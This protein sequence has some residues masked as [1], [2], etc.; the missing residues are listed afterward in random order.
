MRNSNSLPIIIEG[1]K[2]AYDEGMRDY[3]LVVAGWVLNADVFNGLL[4]K[5][6]EYP[7]YFVGSPSGEQLSRLYSS[8]RFLLNLRG[9]EQKM[10]STNFSHEALGVVTIEAIA[11]GCLPIVHDYAGHLETVPNPDLRIDCVPSIPTR[12]KEIVERFSDPREWEGAWSP[13]LEHAETTFSKDAYLENFRSL[14]G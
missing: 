2:R 3:E 5:T 14:L 8:S 6:K 12:M 13:L 7:I 9:I 1:F 10:P 11:H 4:G